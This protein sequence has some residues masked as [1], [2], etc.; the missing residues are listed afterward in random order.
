MLLGYLF[1]DADFICYLVQIPDTSRYI[2]VID[3][4]VLTKIQVAK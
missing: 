4:G 2:L 3:R 1:P